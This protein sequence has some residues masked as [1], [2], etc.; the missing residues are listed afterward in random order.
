MCTIPKQEFQMPKHHWHVCNAHLGLPLVHSCEKARITLLMQGHIISPS[1]YK[2]LKIPHKLTEQ[3]ITCFHYTSVYI[4][5]IKKAKPCHDI[6]MRP[7]DGHL[8]TREK[9][10][11]RELQASVFYIYRVFSNVQSVSSQCNT[12]LSLL[13]LL[14]G[15]EVM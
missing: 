12:R 5:Q 6:T 4:S 11:K 14:Y 1:V 8:R 9:F 15:M 3:T 2:V 13:H 7:H 10:R